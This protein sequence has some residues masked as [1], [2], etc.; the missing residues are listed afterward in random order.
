LQGR[1]ERRQFERERSL[2]LG[3]GQHHHQLLIDGVLKADQIREIVAIMLQRP[4]NLSGFVS[5][6]ETGWEAQGGEHPSPITADEIVKRVFGADF[7]KIKQAL[8][9]GLSLS[10]DARGH[11][12]YVREEPEGS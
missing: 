12:D 9:D 4:M 1:R 11:V 10:F 8:D 3:L 6:Y 7:E 2:G 5:G